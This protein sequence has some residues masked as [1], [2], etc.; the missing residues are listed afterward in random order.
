MGHLSRGVQWLH[1]RSIIH[2]DI[3]PANCL[4]DAKGEK[5]IIG[6]LGCA[7]RSSQAGSV[8]TMGTRGYMAPEIQSGCYGPS[9][10][11]YS[12]GVTFKQLLEGTNKAKRNIFDDI[13]V[14]LLTRLTNAMTLH[15]PEHR[16]TAKQVCRVLQL[17]GQK[18]YAKAG[19]KLGVN[20]Q[21]QQQQVYHPQQPV[22]HPQQPVYHPQHQPLWGG[23]W[24]LQPQDGLLDFQ[25]RMQM[26]QAGY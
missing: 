24:Q 4:F 19:Q 6:D 3:K 18:N 21:P 13:R 12:L 1:E 26:Q 7:I 10:D 23:Q 2:R 25:R 17:I 16:P 22:Y 5:A 11:I 14:T 9:S 15:N 8:G 20:V